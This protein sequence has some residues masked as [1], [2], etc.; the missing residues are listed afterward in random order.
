MRSWLGSTIQGA[1]DGEGRCEE[2]G[3]VDRESEM[4]SE[5]ISEFRQLYARYLVNVWMYK[6]LYRQHF[7]IDISN[8]SPGKSC[9]FIL[10]SNTQSV[11]DHKERNFRVCKDHRNSC[12]YNFNTNLTSNLFGQDLSY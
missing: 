1:A 10:Y 4:E 8:M 12:S 9:L 6:I 7:G 3:A 11:F 2:L 5:V